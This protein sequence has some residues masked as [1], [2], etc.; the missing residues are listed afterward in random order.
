MNDMYFVNNLLLS[1]KFMFRAKWRDVKNPEKVKWVYGA[2]SWREVQPSPI[3]IVGLEKDCN[4]YK[5]TCRKENSM[6]DWNLP[7]PTETYWI[8][9]EFY[10]TITLYIGWNDKKGDNIFVGDIIRFEDNVTKYDG[11]VMENGLIYTKD[12]IDIPLDYFID[13][14][15]RS[16]IHFTIIGNKWDGPRPGYVFENWISNKLKEES[17][18]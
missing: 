18:L 8:P 1:Q 12:S 9:K 16:L 17:E 3:T 13:Y 15:R 14:K 4:L 2:L 6:A 11:I 5:I 10:N 7:F